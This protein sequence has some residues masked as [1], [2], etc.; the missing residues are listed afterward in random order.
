MVSV[1]TDKQFYTSNY[2]DTVRDLQS[3]KFLNG[4][5]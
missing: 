5:V 2:V 1:N 3:L 4:S